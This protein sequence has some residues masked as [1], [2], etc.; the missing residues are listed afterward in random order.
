MDL[1]Q[2]LRTCSTEERRDVAMELAQIQSKES[3][4]AL[5]Y[6]A[7]G[8]LRTQ[9]RHWYT[10]GIKVDHYFRFNDQLTAIEA[11]GETGHRQALDY[12]KSLLEERE[13]DSGMVHIGHGSSDDFHGDPIHRFTYPNVKGDL[14]KVLEWKSCIVCLEKSIGERYPDPF[15][16]HDRYRALQTIQ[17][18]IQ[19]LEIAVQNAPP[20]P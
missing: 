14:G 15:Y 20:N 7:D 13:T 4:E 1:L 16:E 17:R 11:L 6:V 19:K 3:V 18:S 2:R 12:L 5:K 8:N 9:Q 10:L